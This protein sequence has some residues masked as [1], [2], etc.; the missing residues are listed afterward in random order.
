MEIACRGWGGVGRRLAASAS[1]VAAI[2]LACA[3]GAAFAGTTASRFPKPEFSVRYAQP[4]T[5]TPSPR[6]VFNEYVDVIVL[7][8]TILLAS[9]LALKARSRRGIW[10][11]SIF[12]IL[13]FGFWRKGCVCPVG[14]IQNI[15]AALTDPAYAVPF[16]V[17]L[18]FLL[19]ILATL[20]FG[21]TFCAAVCPLGTIQDMFAFRPVRVPDWVAGPLGLVPYA[22]LALAVL[23]VATGTGFIVCQYDPF[24]GFYRLDASLGMVVTGVAMLLIG[25]VVA[26]P[27][28]RFLCPYGVILNWA[29]RF[30]WKHVTITPTDC[31]KCRLCEN[32]CPFGAIGKPTPEKMP[33]PRSVG[34]RRLALLVLMVPVAAVAGGV[35]F[36]VLGGPMS[37]CHRTVALAER[38][39]LEDSG[40]VKGTTLESEAFRSGGQ[41]K[42]D[43]MAQ[44]SE[45]RRSFWMWGWLTGGFL[46]LAAG[47]SMV[48]LAMRRSR[49]EYEIDRGSC[50][51]C[52]R[53]FEYC[54][55]EHEEPGKAAKGN[56]NAGN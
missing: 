1:V 42:A 33:E 48:G 47:L 10:L 19:P 38:V 12:S 53:C 43:L 32:A 36:A 8:V 49:A 15:T 3:P 7:A 5:T 6:A 51:S 28:C 20:V 24:I 14:S 27:Y 44:A 56:G 37:M 54:P 40:A 39:V 16:T 13:Y 52:A 23:F 34:R 50:L 35:L 9:Y 11:L 4:G 45:V 41:S 18:F 25:V 31:V 26:R 22:Y 29:S 21:R 55:R 2:V 30:S 46:G 17:A